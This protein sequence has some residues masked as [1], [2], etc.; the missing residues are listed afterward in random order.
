MDLTFATYIW[1]AVIGSTGDSILLFL[2][3]LA[4]S[5][6]LEPGVIMSQNNNN[7]PFSP[8]G[9][10]I[11]YKFAIHSIKHFKPVK[12]CCCMDLCFSISPGMLMMG[13]PFGNI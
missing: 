2:I 1:T 8:R 12:I 4:F 5:S 6:S 13:G 10:W 7:I 9:M 11:L 3:S